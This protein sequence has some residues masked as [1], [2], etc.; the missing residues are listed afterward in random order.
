MSD[1]HAKRAQR[2]LRCYPSAWRAR[3]G[4]EFTQLLIDD[5]SERPRSMTRT[6]DVV[7][8]GLLA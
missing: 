3:Y 8:S 2:L 5:M 4:Q 6:A 1:P 7:R